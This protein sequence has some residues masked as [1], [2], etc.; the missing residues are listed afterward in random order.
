MPKQSTSGHPETQQT[1]EITKSVKIIPTKFLF[2]KFCSGNYIS[3]K[4]QTDCLRIKSPTSVLQ[5][6]KLPYLF[7]NE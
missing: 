2:R 3:R 5:N 4:K 7:M 6:L 1:S